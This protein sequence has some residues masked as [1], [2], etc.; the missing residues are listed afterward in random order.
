[1][2]G[3]NDNYK[4]RILTSLQYT[5]KLLED[6]LHALAP[7]A[8]PL[9]SGFVQDL[10][11]AETRCVE[12]YA[13]KIREQMGKLLERCHIELSVPAIPSSGKLRTGLNSMDLTL[14]D[15]YP[16]KMRGYGKIDAAAARDLSWNLQEIRRL[17]NLLLSFLSDS[18][19]SHGK[20]SIPAHMDPDFAGL[21][22]R[23][24]KIIADYGFVEFLPALNAVAR[25]FDA[26]RFKI[27]VFGR[28]DS[29]K[30]AFIN[31][32]LDAQLLPAGKMLLTAF[33]V[34]LSVSGPS[35]LT[36]SFLDRVEEYSL[37][38]LAGFVT[39][40]SNPRNEKRVTAVNASAPAA[41][42]REGTAL[43][44]MPGIGY[45]M[46]GGN[47][48]AC[49]FMPEM[50]FGLVLMDGRDSPGPGEVNLLKM[51]QNGGIPSAVWI[52]GGE[53]S[54]SEA[55]AKA[56]V[57]IRNA[58]EPLLGRRAEI[59]PEDS[60][61]ALDAAAWLER[62]TA[63]F[64]LKS[65]AIFRE[66]AGRRIQCLQNAI[67]ATLEM[68]AG[69]GAAPVH[70]TEPAQEILRP[71]DES[72]AAFQQHWDKE[73]DKMAG[74]A[75]SIL[76]QVAAALAAEARAADPS[77]GISPQQFAEAIL[78]AIALHLQPLMKE[79]RDLSD[80]IGADLL[81]LRAAG[82]SAVMTGAEPA[83]P[84]DMPAPVLPFLENAA[85]QL[86]AVLARA[87]QAARAR[88][89]RKE[90]ED[91]CGVE[92]RHSLDELRPRLARWFTLTANALRESVRL[93][94][95]PMRYRSFIPT[96][97]EDDEDRRRAIDFLRG[98]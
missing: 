31:R 60:A 54:S 18:R 66:S 45:F 70:Q 97:G 6:G 25:G 43:H 55:L 86:S 49:D 35:Q 12:N 67:L 71:L 30:A 62:V 23:I 38:H 15:I 85:I 81:R 57:S 27:G 48:P 36:V 92:L 33:P 51:L 59:G 72:L 2:T 77:R 63:P 34:Q 24:E 64:V 28:D 89:I 22:E 73:F 16:E 75:G 80:R 87:G 26:Y 29:G 11:A 44:V 8:K 79:Y 13:R 74:W 61:P 40:E 4:R 69:D 94:T 52:S 14:E 76:D 84:M 91:R 50:D 10:S 78:S 68:A 5:D 39:E 32:L 37:A 83:Q 82:Y 47:A 88:S 95:D 7:G 53:S 90:L 20:G 93:Q 17:I 19:A 9:F 65:R 56:H 42:L 46:L 98:R 58:V 41:G 3:L 1:M 96:S 21:Y